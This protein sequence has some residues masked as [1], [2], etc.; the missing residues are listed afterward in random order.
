M[1]DLPEN[2][3]SRSMTINRL[4]RARCIPGGNQEKLT[5]RN[6]RGIRAKSSI[7]TLKKRMTRRHAARAFDW[8]HMTRLCN[9]AAR[10]ESS[11]NRR[12]AK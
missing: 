2:P 7:S 12:K 6:R 9:P 10:A 3:P 4:A 8:F 1:E 5:T 11:H